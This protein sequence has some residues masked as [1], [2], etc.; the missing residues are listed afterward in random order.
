MDTIQPTCSVLPVHGSIACSLCHA[1]KPIVF[2]ETRTESEKSDWSITA[3]PLAWGNQRPEVLVLGFSKG[4][5][6]AN[7]LRRLKHNE[8]PYRGG[9]PA[10]A[11]ILAHVGLL[12]SAP[13]KDLERMVENA[14]ADNNGRFGW[15]SLIRCTVEQFKNGKWIGTGGGM[16]DRFMKTDFG[17]QVSSNCATRFLRELPVE[18]KLIIMFGRGTKNNYVCAARQSFERARPG[19]WEQINNMAY[20]DGK[21]TVVHVEHFAA[22]GHLLD[23][24]LGKNGNE[25]ENLGIM[26]RDAVEKAL[27]TSA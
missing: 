16:L 26:A 20:S 6:Q 21:I 25:R 22:Q 12:P 15:G 10:V 23:D 5:S 9:R 27:A 11:K 3:N 13:Q 8:I 18:T 4:P 2:D 19:V 1:N 17:Q 7:D 14:I 24:W